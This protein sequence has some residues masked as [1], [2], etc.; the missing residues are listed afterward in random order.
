MVAGHYQALIESEITATLELK[1]DGTARY[2]VTWLDGE[3]KVVLQRYSGAGRWTRQAATVTVTLPLDTR[4]GVITYEVSACLPYDNRFPK[5]S[6]GLR[7]IMS[8]MPKGH[9]WEMW[10]SDEIKY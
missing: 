5:C 1:E 3:A 9:T 8:D 4:D 6:P 7:P 2:V 10:K